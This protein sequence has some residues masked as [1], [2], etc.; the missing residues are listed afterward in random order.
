MKKLFCLLAISFV[1][2]GAACSNTNDAEEPASDAGLAT[3]DFVAQSPNTS[4]SNI[5][6]AINNSTLDATLRAEARVAANAISGPWKEVYKGAPTELR[7]MYA[8]APNNIFAVGQDSLVV[9]FDGNRWYQMMVNQRANLWGVHGSSEKAI[10]AVGE[11]KILKYDG[12]NWTE[13]YS[14]SYSMNMRT[15]WCHTTGD[16]WAAGETGTIRKRSASSTY[17]SWSTQT[18]TAKQTLNALWG[19][20]DK[21]IY[22][23]G[24]QGTIVKYNGSQWA[25]IPSPTTSHL[26]SIYGTSSTDIW[27][28]GFDGTI[29][30]YDG[31][32]IEKVEANSSNY[33]YG[34]LANS[35]SDVFAVSHPMFAPQDGIMHFDGKAWTKIVMPR[36][37]LNFNAICGSSP[38]DIYVLTK[39]NIFKYTPELA[40][41]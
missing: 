41:N 12:T 23:V 11:G 26:I 40:S 36:T 27:A 19:L 39:G 21:E 15:V 3:T 17:A 1:L 28:A 34:V 2:I 37:G 7:G 6:A 25:T 32:K 30:H 24:N 13:D 10:F 4:A 38:T 35:A 8:Q 14:S 29:L 18:S 16:C 9:R 20:S 31:T 22:A 33:F 5:D